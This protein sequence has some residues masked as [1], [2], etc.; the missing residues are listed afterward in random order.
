[1]AGMFDKVRLGNLE[2]KNRFIAAP[3][4]T[5]YGNPNGEV[6][7]KHLK[8]YERLAMGGVSLI[9]TEPTAVL[10]SGRE[11]PKQLCIDEDRCVGELKKIT[12]V[13]HK[14]GSLAC[15]NITHAGRAANPKATGQPPLAPS[16]IMCPATKQTPQELTKE[17]IEEII[18]AFGE[19]A[20]R[21]KDAGFDVIE[22]Q[23]GMGYIIAQFLK[24]RTNKRSDEY[25]QDKML[26]VR[27]VFEEVFSKA[28]GLP[29]IVRIS[30]NEFVDGGIT[31]E[32]N[33][34]ILGLAKEFGAVAVHAGLGNACDTP[35]W[36]YSATFTPVEKQVEAF[37][38]IKGLTDLPV[39]VD[40]RMA[41]KDKIEQALSEGWADLIGLGKSLA[42]D[43]FFVKKL[44]E[45]KEDE[46]YYCGGCLQGCL[47]KVKAGVGLGCIINP[48]VNRDEFD[49][50]DNHLRF[51][52]A[53]GGP[54]GMAAATYAAMR[55][56]S[57]VLFEKKK[58]GGQFNLAVKPPF[59]DMMKRP[60]NS[61]IRDLD[62]YGV[63]VRYEEANYEK[64][65]SLNPDV[66]VVATG[67]NSTV[68]KIEGIENEN[69][70]DAF[71]YFENEGEIKG[72]RALVLGVGLIGRETMEDL[73]L[74]RG[75]EEVVGVDILEELSED[76]TLT[77]LKGNPKAKIITGA[78]LERF[79][80]NGAIISREG[81]EEKLGKFDI[82]ITSIGT[83]PNRSLYD[84]IKDKFGKV[85]IIGDANKVADI[86][87]ATH[88]AYDLVAK[89]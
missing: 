75:F 70:M 58:L 39:I 8:F 16:P 18:M 63:E 27:R 77:R 85:E 57:V 19:A 38:A 44:Q 32:D 48:F 23:A 89:Y 3:V 35:P 52:V 14:N 33:K 46:I 28:D 88:Q 64:I 24:E 12:D 67:A 45:G 42:C 40:G 47:L 25:G 21:A 41:D 2:L 7:E 82:V 71:A 79:T 72:K 73:L 5:A 61:L 10:K 20:R 56:H 43:Q 37:K 69:V 86:Y 83:K 68:P 49:K 65:K 36:Y 6:N 9:I 26:F 31:P 51:V 78:K 62:R 30:G 15:L 53:G 87:E 29:V 1:M 54:A 84:E 81:N 11:H 74:K 66:V 50:S 55:G 34:P 4:K 76:F 80:P 60:L 17:Q 59:K 22:L 13:I